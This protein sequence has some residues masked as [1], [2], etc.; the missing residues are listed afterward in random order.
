M[1]CCHHRQSNNLFDGE[2]ETFITPLDSAIWSMFGW[3][4]EVWSWTGLAK[5]RL[6]IKDSLLV[7]LCTVND[8]FLHFVYDKE[9]T[10]WVL[11]SQI[12][13]I[14]YFVN[15][16]TWAILHILGYISVLKLNCTC[17][18]RGTPTFGLQVV[19]LQLGCCLV[20]WPVLSALSWNCVECN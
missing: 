16:H 6:G 14:L 7:S 18:A 13:F 2:L 10:D 1:P 4:C 11:Y 15:G 12:A 20:S 5:P 8:G 17:L 9:Q 3:G 19:I